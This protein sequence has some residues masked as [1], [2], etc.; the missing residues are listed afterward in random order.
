MKKYMILDQFMKK[1]VYILT[2]QSNSTTC[3]SHVWPN[4]NI[5]MYDEC[6]LQQITRLLKLSLLEVI[7]SRELAE[8]YC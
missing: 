6:S 2:K 5:E 4:P 8:R 7:F 3:D 1:E